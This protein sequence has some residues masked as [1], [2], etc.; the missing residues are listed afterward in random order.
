MRLSIFAGAIISLVLASHAN[1]QQ[2][3]L[4]RSGL[5]TLKANCT[6]QETDWDG[7][8]HNCHSP[9]QE[10]ATVEG[11]VLVQNSLSIR[12]ISE[13]GSEKECRTRFSDFVEVVPGTDITQPTKVYLQAYAVSPRGP[14]GVGRGW[15]G[16][17]ASLMQVEIPRYSDEQVQRFSE[18]GAEMLAEEESLDTESA[19]DDE[20][21]VATEV[22]FDEYPSGEQE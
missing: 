3:N 19:P 1:A 7:A 10:Y 21:V 17:E 15:M 5:V 20:E 11:F 4:A 2:Q 18:L 16:C 13:S 8:R 6:T 9:W 22:T 12:R 14:F